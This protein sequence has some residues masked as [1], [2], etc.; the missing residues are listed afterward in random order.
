MN[1]K[2]FIIPAAFVAMALMHSCKKSFLELSPQGVYDLG[3]LTNKKGVDGMLINAYATLDGRQ[4]QQNGG[5]SNWL[6]G[7]I[8]G[9]DA[10]KGTEP[11]DMVDANPVMRF[12]ILPSNGQLTNK[13]TGIWDGVG[14]ANQVLKVLPQASDISAADAKQIE[15][16]ARFIRAFMHFEGKKAFGNIPF[17]DETVTDYKVPNTDASGNYLNI[18]PKIEE[19]FKWAYDNLD[20]VRPHVGRANK[21]AAAAYLAKAYMFQNKFAE[22]KALFDVIIANG[23]NSRGTPYALAANYHNNFRVTSENN[24]E[25]VFSIQ[26]SYGDGANT[27]GNYD[28]TLNYPHGGSATT[29]KPGACCGFFQPSQNLVNSFR[30]DAAGLPMPTTYNN[31]DVTSDE[32]LASTDAFTPYSGN[33]DPRLDWTV[34]RRGIPYYDWGIHPGRNWIRMVT[35]GGPYSPK[36]N[37]YYKADIGTLA[38]TVGWGFANNALNFTA[39]RF[40][41]VLLMAAEAEVEVGSL[42]TARDYVNRVRRRAAA[43]PVL[44]GANPAANY[45]VA[46]YTAPWAS[47]EAARTA[48]RFERKIEL[49]MEGHRFFDLVRWGIAEEVLNNEYFPKEA[50]RRASALDGARFTKNK[51]EYFPIPEFA[52][53][54]SVRDGQATLKQNPGY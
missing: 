5:A 4:D 50:Q 46:E 34:G 9:G 54:Q 6:W 3:S 20:E 10:Y 8:T 16:E 48:V 37:T 15:G 2:L 13:W 25:T 47:K 24:S 45:V 44:N 53:T 21:W 23:K 33:L 36:K 32:N 31:V 28:N 30:T 14:G 41:D 52:I 51:N 26:A 17:L 1:K 42:Q 39:M 27:N 18:W 19:D 11:T 43:S 38:G 7:S 35:Y 40:A 49:G 29:E 22:A 12:E